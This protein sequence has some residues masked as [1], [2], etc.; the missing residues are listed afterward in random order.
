M[1]L[2]GSVTSATRY[3]VHTHFTVQRNIPGLGN[4]ENRL[5]RLNRTINAVGRSFALIYAGLGLRRL[6]GAFVSIHTEIE[7]ARVGLAGLIT[8]ITGMETPRAL[9]TAANSVERLR[10]AA[11]ALPGDLPQYLRALQVIYGPTRMAG[12]DM[13]RAEKLAELAVVAGS[14]LGRG[15]IGMKTLPLDVQQALTRGIGAQ[16]TPDL[17]NLLRAIDPKYG[18]ASFFN[19]LPRPERLRIVIEAL[20]RM[21]ESAKIF[22]QTFSAQRDT[23]RDNLREM[24]RQLSGGLF[25]EVKSDLIDINEWLGKIID[26]NTRWVNQVDKQLLLSYLKLKL[27]VLRPGNMATVGQGAAMAAGGLGAR[28]LAASAGVAAASRGVPGVG[29]LVNIVTLIGAGIAN[30]MAKFPKDTEMFVASLVS[31]GAG[32]GRFFGELIRLLLTN[33]LSEFVLLGLLQALTDVI[34]GIAL[35][36]H[37]LAD[38]LGVIN[39]L[40]DLLPE[41]TSP[42]GTDGAI[43]QTRMFRKGV[44][45]FS[46]WL[47][48]SGQ[49]GDGTPLWNTGLLGSRN[50]RFPSG[51]LGGPGARGMGDQ[52]LE[53]FMNLRSDAIN[54]DDLFPPQSELDERDIVGPGDTNL[55]GPITI[56]IRAEKVDNPDLVARSFR[57]VAERFSEYK[58]GGRAA[59]AP[60]TG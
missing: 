11:A 30:I 9:E 18:E 1:S 43:S 56:V 29:M 27:F 38:L 23:F 24:G 54:I 41:L 26:G 31:L 16:I 13:R 51:I 35:L 36:A 45:S 22:G 12:G 33:P 49:P 52:R 39:D 34:D 2:P 25:E 42:R 58:R 59:L 7:D 20:E 40:V 57:E 44:G 15:A 14:T 47:G 48:L 10:K 55:N 37:G 19:E 32:L 8:A 17:N 50:T 21:Q 46:E 53:N 6:A 28:Y 5:Q 4:I 3:V 60:K